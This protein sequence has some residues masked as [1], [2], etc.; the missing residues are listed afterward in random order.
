VI[1]DF[2]F[3]NFQKVNK[4]GNEPSHQCVLNLELWN[5]F[6][7]YPFGFGICSS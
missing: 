6:V 4:S 5:G 7:V 2:D 3:G 1:C